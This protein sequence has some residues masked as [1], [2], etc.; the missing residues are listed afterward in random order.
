MTE[1]LKGPPKDPNKERS[2]L[3][4]LSSPTSL[5]SNVAAPIGLLNVTSM[6]ENVGSV[7]L[8]S[9]EVVVTTNGGMSVVVKFHAVAPLIPAKSWPHRSSNAVSATS[10]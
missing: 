9:G 10:T 7:P 6:A 5:P 4:K 1:S 3:F 2:G 8:R